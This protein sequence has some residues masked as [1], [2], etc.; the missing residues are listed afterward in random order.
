[1]PYN[2]DLEQKLDSLAPRF[3]AL[4]KKKMFGGIG[5]LMNGNMVFGIH[6]Q[7]LV[8]RTSSESTE[9]LLKNEF[10]SVF[11]ISGR[12]MKGWLLISLEGLKTEKRLLELLNLAVDYVKTLPPK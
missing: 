7:A 6:R 10:V 8:L 1:M 2:L 9:E 11:E 12:P 5:Y 3:G 4:V